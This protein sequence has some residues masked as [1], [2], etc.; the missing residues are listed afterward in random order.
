MLVAGIDEA[1]RGPCIGPMVIACIVFDQSDI[2]KLKKIGVKDSKL[3]TPAKREELVPKIL[4]LAKEYYIVKISPKEIDE[5]KVSLN[6]L[7]AIKIAEI[8]KKIDKKVQKVTID[9]PDPDEENFS[10]RIMKHFNFSGIIVARHKADVRY[11]EVSAASILAKVKRDEEIQAIKESIKYDFGSGYPSDPRTIKFLES[12]KGN[13]PE[14]VRES[15]ST[16]SKLNSK[17]KKLSDFI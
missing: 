16:I 8:L 10:R 12:L 13:Y 6:E 4:T 1:G 2:L 9:A 5:K 3:L 11:P 7:E 17:Q 14:Y 15:W